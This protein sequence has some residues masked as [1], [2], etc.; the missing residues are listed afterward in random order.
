MYQYRITVNGNVG[1]ILNNYP[2]EEWTKIANI[3]EERGINATLERRLITDTGIL[4]F[5]GG[6]L[7]QGY[8]RLKDKVV[9][10]WEVLAEMEDR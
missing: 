10:N 5:F 7:P 1:A 2:S 9:C 4:E 6:E 3:F 8:M